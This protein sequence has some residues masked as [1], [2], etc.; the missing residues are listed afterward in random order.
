MA[1]GRRRHPETW[2]GQCGAITLPHS[3]LGA[4]GGSRAPDQTGC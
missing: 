2:A 1:A 3:R 4:V